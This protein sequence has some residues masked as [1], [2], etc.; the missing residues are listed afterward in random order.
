MDLSLLTN[1]AG[2]LVAVASYIPPF[3]IILAIIIFVHELGHFLVAR[4]CGV[5]VDAFSLGF[6]R[7]IFGWTDRH[8][9]RWRVAM[10]PL[11][12][13]VKFAGDENAASVP[14]AAAIAAMSP[15]ERRRSFY[16][17]PVWQRAAIV[18][19]GPAANF[20]LAIAIFA[21]AFM[22]VGR[23]AVEAHVSGVVAG[24]P[25]E[26]AGFAPGDVITAI[27][28]REVDAFID[29]LRRVTS[30]GGDELAFSV[31]RGDETVTLFATP[32]QRD[33]EDDFG[34]PY[35][36]GFLGIENRTEPGEVRR[37]V[38]GPIGALAAGAQ[39]TAYITTRTVEVIWG[40]ITLEQSP[41]QFGGP[42]RVAKLSGDMWS[43]GPAAFLGL[44]AMLSISIGLINLFPIPI[45]DGGHLLF[46]AIEAVRG[47]PLSDRAQDVG[48]RIG[49]GLVLLLM[50]AVTFNDVQLFTR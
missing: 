10:L 6:G 47:R 2:T 4:W 3:L 36:A 35:S 1:A 8:G 30:A 42:L 28:G 25:A 41:K 24:S 45:L 16:A 18:A 9:T 12:G 43:L 19:A 21:V 49:L 15:E 34:T 46:Y 40:V 31:R 32:E 48:F 26:A 27:D 23:P 17:K 37:E 50:V 14:D 13:Y 29:V 5:A 39:E 7:E 20:L 38:F 44:A 22:T 33:M 11:G